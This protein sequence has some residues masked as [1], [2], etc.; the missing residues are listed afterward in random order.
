MSAERTYPHPDPPPEGEGTSV[1]AIER[2]DISKLFAGC[3]LSTELS[4]TIPREGMTRHRGPNGV[5]KV[6]AG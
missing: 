6:D 2:S 3:M 5:G 4:L 1:P